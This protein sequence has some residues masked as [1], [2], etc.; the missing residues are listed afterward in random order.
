MSPPLFESLELLGRERSLGLDLSLRRRA[1]F[2]TGAILLRLGQNYFPRRLVFETG[3]AIALFGVVIVICLAGSV[4][5]VRAAAYGAEPVERAAEHEALDDVLDAGGE[6][7]DVGRLR[8]DH[9]GHATHQLGALPLL[10]LAEHVL[11]ARLI[12]PQLTWGTSPQDVIAISD[13]IPDPRQVSDPEQ[14]ESMQRAL[15]YM[16]LKGGE[17]ITDIALANLQRFGVLRHEVSLEN[18][19]LVLPDDP[20][21]VLRVA[22]APYIGECLGHDIVTASGTTLLGADNKAERR[23]VTLGQ[24]TA[25]TAVIAK[26]LKEGET[27]VI[28]G[29]V[30]GVTADGTKM[31]DAQSWAEDLAAK[32]VNTAPG[33]SP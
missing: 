31:L 3:D 32:F 12:T 29:Q 4:I 33:I 27:V 2:V 5:G 10:E 14:R 1:G 13:C 9:D 30:D 26:G 15:D 25:L 24:S 22:D 23:P 18:G 8:V 21:A 19:D 7:L 6:R 17:K 16:G 11:D 20:T 28:E